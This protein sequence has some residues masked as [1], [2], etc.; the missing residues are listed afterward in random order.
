[1]VALF[2]TWT[3]TV[4]CIQ[5]MSGGIPVSVRTFALPRVTRFS[6]TVF[7]AEALR[8]VPDVRIVLSTSWVWRYG[9]AKTTKDLPPELRSRVIG[10]TWNPQVFS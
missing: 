7:L 6:S 10:A 3:S 1:M 5:R 2:S 9:L 4:C 8:A